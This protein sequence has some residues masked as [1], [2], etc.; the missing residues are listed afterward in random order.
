VHPVKGAVLAE[1]LGYDTGVDQPEIILAPLSRVPSLAA[2]ESE[3]AKSLLCIRLQA[4]VARL[5]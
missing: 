3:Q 5:R 1:E 2:E 4:V